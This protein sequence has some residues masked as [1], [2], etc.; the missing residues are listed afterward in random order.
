M[1]KWLLGVLS[2]VFL[3]FALLMAAGW[4]GIYLQS[5]PPQ[6]SANTT[7]ILDLDGD[8][9]E[10]VPPDL[11]G[12][13]LGEPEQIMFLALLTDIDKAT[14]DSRITGML[15]KASNLGI[16]WGKLQ[17]L[18]QSL[19]EFQKHGK[20]LTAALEVAGTR[21][22]FLASAAS[23][24]YLSPGGFLNLKGM[25]AEVMFFKDGLGKLG[26]QADLEHIGK[27]KN[28][29]DQFTDNRMSDA[30]RE[31]TTSML[32]SIYG[33]FLEAVA[34]ARRQPVEEMRAAIEE[35]GPFD[36]ERAKQAGL[37]DELL[38][39]DQVLKQLETASQGGEFHKM[40]MEDYHRVPAKD[41][42]LGTGPRIALIYAVGDIISGED[43]SSPLGGKTLGA[44]TMAEVLESVAKD[45]S[46]KGVVVRIDSGGGDA[47]ASDNIWRR[48]NL[49]REK[50]PLV[51]SMSDVAASGGYYL[52]MTGDPIVAEP[53]TLT[54]SIG[55]VYGKLNLKGFYDKLGIN[56]EVIAR[57]KFSGLDSDYGSYTPEE[58]QR[59][60][61]LMDN[62]YQD[63]VKKVATARK[64]APEDVDKIAQGR[65]WT[66]EQAKENGL[67]DEVG[68]FP[69]ALE[70]VKQKAKIPLTESVE[71]VEFPKRKS[72]F[73]LIISRAERGEVRG[74]FGGEL[75]L[76]APLSRQ[77]ARMLADWSQLES[78]AQRPLWTRL[79]ATFTFR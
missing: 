10:Q 20:K 39:E 40:D 65:V 36:P 29:S 24:V 19:E 38:Y 78:L 70:L 5:R 54:G 13:L 62:F 16:G 52:A 41:L 73:A 1:K 61:Q 18:R 77:F 33:N 27:Y 17:Q 22:Y 49:L 64:M 46:I 59:V 23:K 21:E 35:S 3:V 32:D 7:L 42:G 12:Q 76:P 2:G 25:R 63:F 28:F 11:A 9:P 6:V 4:L 60:R 15:L 68:G 51:F 53:G 55:I 56:K 66:G 44:E 37:V 57:G 26:I 79:P 69:R 71:L 72:L 74:I 14:A 50:K 75:R 8:I 43:Q 48:M 45:D 47:I 67:I 30:F 58:R 31:A 34:D